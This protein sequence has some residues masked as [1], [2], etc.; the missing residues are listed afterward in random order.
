MV[1][2][3]FLTEIRILRNE[4]ETDMLLP[5]A[6]GT[7]SGVAS[8]CSATRM[9][10]GRNFRKEASTLCLAYGSFAFFRR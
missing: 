1:T 10:P 7:S 4:T 8:N 3:V 5:E 9:Q 2:S 6:A